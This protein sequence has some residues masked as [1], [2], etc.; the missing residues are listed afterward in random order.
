MFLK[1]NLNF[2]SLLD[3]FYQ[4]NLLSEKDCKDYVFSVPGKHFRCEK[5]LKLMIKKSKC[6]D[7]VACLHET[8]SHNDIWEKFQENKDQLSFP[9]G[10][11][12]IRKTNTGQKY[13]EFKPEK[14]KLIQFILLLSF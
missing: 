3:E 6:K 11:V 10:N 8:R 5:F 2:E 14:I 12:I 9:T 7:F 4:K 13:C 1:K